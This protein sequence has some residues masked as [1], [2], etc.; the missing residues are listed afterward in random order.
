MN[1]LPWDGTDM[2]RRR[3]LWMTPAAIWLLFTFWY[4]DLGGPLTDK[5]ISA[6]MEKVRSQYSAQ[7]INDLE[8]FLRRDT[9]RQFLMVNNIDM[10][11][12]PPPFL[13]VRPNLPHGGKLGAKAKQVSR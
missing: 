1:N 8:A 3:L 9:G 12:N 10:N 2:T 13:A 4:T 7:Q 5:E 11:D 6:G